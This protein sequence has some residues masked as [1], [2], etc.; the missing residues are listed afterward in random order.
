MVATVIA[1]VAAVCIGCMIEMQIQIFFFYKCLF[2][3]ASISFHIL[4]IFYDLK[5]KRVSDFVINYL[6]KCQESE[7]K[8]TEKHNI[9]TIFFHFHV[10][11]T[12]GN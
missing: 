2:I 7:V 3:W 9:E 11:E 10:L 4:I 8:E 12:F 6:W 1:T 5:S